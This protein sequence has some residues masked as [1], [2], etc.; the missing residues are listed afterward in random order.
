MSPD[1]LPALEQ[2]AAEATTPAERARAL[3]ALGTELSRRGQPRR[4]LECARQARDIATASGDPALDAQTRHALARAHFYLGEFVPA[5]GFLIEA[6]QIYR[7]VGDLAGAATAFA[8]VGLCQMR[9]GAHEDAAASLRQA[10]DM[11]RQQ[12]LKTLEINV[13]SSLV[14]VHVSIDQLDEAEHHLALGLELVQATGDRNLQTKLL[15]NGAYTAR[16]RADAE[17]ER[18]HGDAA[19]TAWQRALDALTQ[20]L[21]LARDLGNQ[22]D[23]AHS[24]GET[25]A[26]LRRLGRLEEA[27]AALQATL[28]L[29]ATVDSLHLRTEAVLELGELRV[30]Q[31]REAEAR[32]LLDEAVAYARHMGARSELAMACR[33]LSSLVER[34]GDAAGALALFKEYHAIGQTELASSRK[35]AAA[36]GRLW[37]EYQDAA[38]RAALYQQRAESLEADRAALSREAQ[39]ALVAAQQDP[40]TGLLNRR[41][42]EQRL[43]A[44]RVERPGRRQPVSLAVVDVDHFKAINDGWSHAIGDAVLSAL[45]RL[46]QAHCRHA[47]L[48]ARWGGDEFVLLLIGA[49]LDAAQAIVHRLLGAVRQRDWHQQARG[50]T[51]TLSVGLAAWAEG[52]PFN[53]VL[54]AADRSLY[55]AKRSGRDRSAG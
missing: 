35:H 40:L 27:G 49:D 52:T 11:A 41:G 13:H 43:Q 37:L 19:R 16:K 28:A 10:L 3:N 20:A 24:L 47:D 32:K 50:L 25:G 7:D 8:G 18:G 12:G 42:F 4:A 51:V 44:L 48:A 1:P 36:A 21:Q 33:A 6:G 45:G 15:H 26:V 31:G 9:L 17:A 54:T 5:L 55:E 23:E 39:A 30:A 14:A 53:T 46:L 2:A 22:Y 38:R 34:Q 29:S